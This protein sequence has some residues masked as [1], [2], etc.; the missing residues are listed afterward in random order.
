MRAQVLTTKL[1]AP[2]D[3]AGLVPR[4]RLLARLDDG[5]QRALTVLSAP[6]GSGKSTLVSAWAAAR[7]RPIAWLSLD[8]DDRDV[9]R[10][11]LHLVA[12]LRTVEPDVGEGVLAMLAAGQLPP[13][14][15]ILA[16]LLNEVHALESAIVLVL[17]DYH[18]VDD[19][20]LDQIV[21]YLLER[22]PPNLHLIVTTRQ[23]PDLPLAALRARGELIEVRATDLRFTLDETAAFLTR[24][25]GL[26]LPADAIATLEARTEGW[27]AGLQLAALSLQG[28]DDVD[29]FLRAF[30]GD[31][32]FIVDY[33]VDEVLRRQRDDVRDFLLRTSVLDR[34]SGALCDA[35]TGRQGSDAML[36]R[37]E[38]GNLFLIPLDDRRRWYRYH[39]LFADVLRAHLQQQHP[40][41]L[42]ELHARA[43]RWHEAHGLLD[44]AVRHALAA[45][46]DGHAAD[47]IENAW[48]AMDSTFRSAAWQAW[49]EALP[50]DLVRA[51]PGLAVGHAWALLNVGALEAADR[52]LD[53]AEAAL[54]ASGPAADDAALRSLA[55]TAASARAYHALATG[56]PAV[57]VAQAQ[58]ALTLLDPDDAVAR[59]VPLGLLSLAHWANGDLDA[60]Y[61]MLSQAME[62][63]LAAG[64]LA[65]GLSG[66]FALADI[67]AE[68]GRLRQAART[69]RAALERVAEAG[70][71]LPGAAELHVGLAGILLEQGDPAE[72]ER[73]LRTADALGERAV[74]PGD[75]ARLRAA[76]AEVEAGLGHVDH[77]LEL[78]DAAERLRIRS[79]MP[80]LRPAAALRAGVWLEQ[81]RLAEAEAWAR[82]R[83]LPDPDDRRYLR[84]FEQ[85]MAV[86]VRL[87]A[88][89]RD[90]DDAELDGI[91]V[92]LEGLRS[93]AEAGGWNGSLLEILVL[94]ALTERARGD[95]AAALD[96]LARALAL[97]E[98]QGHLR[99]FVGEG[100]AMRALLREAVKHKA[101]GA[102]GRRVLA[103]F[104]SAAGTAAG[105][106]GASSTAPIE[107][108]TERELEVLRLLGSELSGPEIARH[109]RVSPNTVRTHIKNVY[110][111]L[112]VNSRR[113]AVRC[114]EEI[115]LP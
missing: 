69:Y 75:E 106:R 38:R 24:A 95:T 104:G 83:G 63:F 97:A 29:G 5:A 3:R 42:P 90:P 67:L 96:R 57:S 74:L 60:A 40:D 78:L 22:R 102:Y 27:I 53:E 58:R 73:Q 50:D 37:L 28:R 55:G 111:K 45:G 2:P 41:A 105:H 59:G 56:R 6:A 25:M 103:A 10:L 100:R 23:D 109:L 80:E 44:E 46:D 70:L 91:A 51:R 79:P 43:S 1:H 19:A 72:A 92:M 54:A 15:R 30:A 36:G 39:P 110:A 48:R 87:A 71:E 18:A 112:G 47:V 21:A 49:V 77:A 113:A 85:R 84:A 88:A 114:A 35:L 33:L 94:Q 89:E 52:R 11:L 16:E 66:T 17:D 31:H 68:Q 4:A 65:A 99:V 101:G 115:G 12:A 86:R 76:M 82:E 64:N 14:E 34:L 108:L 20:S 81:G 7:M 32:R 13:T 107:P 26:E 62:G 98:P 9:R 8:P 61:G 93:S